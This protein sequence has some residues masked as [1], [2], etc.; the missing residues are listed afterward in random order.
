MVIDPFHA[1]WQQVAVPD[2]VAGR[3]AV[4]RAV[5]VLANRRK[6]ITDDKAREVLFGSEQYRR[7]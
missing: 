7:H 4:M 5:E 3:P 2:E 1:R 6:P